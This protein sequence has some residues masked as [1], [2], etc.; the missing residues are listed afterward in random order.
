MNESDA[1]INGSDGKVI[2]TGLESDPDE[3]AQ[4]FGSE[5]KEGCVEEPVE[6]DL[7]EVLEHSA[8]QRVRDAFEQRRKPLHAA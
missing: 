6:V 3:E 1:F 7:L 4:R 2:G 8:E 5:G